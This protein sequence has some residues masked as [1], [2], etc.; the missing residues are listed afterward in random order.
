MTVIIGRRFRRFAFEEISESLQHRVDS[1]P[2][3]TQLTRS[4]R[5]FIQEGLKRFLI[6]R[7]NTG[8]VSLLNAL[9]QEERAI[10]TNIPGTTKLR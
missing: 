7:P 1:S 4:E 3:P 5:S 6:G 8:K 10:V 2:N 9:L